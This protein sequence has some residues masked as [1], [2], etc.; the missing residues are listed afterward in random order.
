MKKATALTLAGMMAV[1]SVASASMSRWNGFGASQAFI[2]D[3][4]DI[5]TLPGVAASNPDATYLEFGY[6][7]PTSPAFVNPVAGGPGYGG[8]GTADTAAYNG[9]A[10]PANAWGGS[11]MTLGPGVLAIWGNRPYTEMSTIRNPLSPVAINTPTDFAGVTFNF[12]QPAQTIDLIYAFKISDTLELGIGINNASNNTRTETSTTGNPTTYTENNSGDF[13]ISLGGEVKELGAI[14]LLE[15]GLQYNMASASLVANNGS[16]TNKNTVAGTDLDL[17]V[18]MDM[19]GEGNSFS[20]I[21]VGLGMESLKFKTEPNTAPAANSFVESTY[22]NMS[23]NLGY[24]MGKTSDKGMGLGGFMLSGNTLGSKEPWNVS[25]IN[26]ETDSN[27]NLAFM[28]GGESKIKEWLT[29]RAG[30]STNLWGNNTNVNENGGGGTTT[31]TTTTTSNAPFSTISTG[32]SLIF[33]DFTI[34]GV[35]NQDILYTGTY[36]VSGMSAALN[37]QVSATW[38]WGGSKE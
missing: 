21:E 29:G 11:H 14:S 27:L 34:D 22:D 8:P 5:W 36:F 25:E 16:V 2:A 32:V 12:N 33:G 19:K 1:S 17:R 26:T 15:V 24:A 35:L 30:F 28:T 31:K 13:G 3:V 4:Q 9:Y 37:T 6:N 38:G 7:D 18:G 20:R 10:N 23:W